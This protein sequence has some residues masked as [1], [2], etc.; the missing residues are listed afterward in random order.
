MARTL[1]PR[2]CRRPG[3]HASHACTPALLDLTPDV[4]ALII[5]HTE[6]CSFL[7]IHIDDVIT[8]SVRVAV[9][10][11]ATPSPQSRRYCS[12]ACPRTLAGSSPLPFSAMIAVVRC[13]DVQRN[14]KFPDWPPKPCQ[15]CHTLQGHN[16]KL[17]FEWACTQALLRYIFQLACQH[18]VVAKPCA[19]AY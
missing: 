10:F 1:H 17:D 11:I 15:H 7:K 9:V 2:L 4:C 14:V 18:A 3:L 6:L 13:Y 8:S 19:T 12:S 16:A 5:L